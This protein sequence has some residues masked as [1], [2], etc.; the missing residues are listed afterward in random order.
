MGIS[1][2]IGRKNIG[3]YRCKKGGWATCTTSIGKENGRR[4][5]DRR[6]KMVLRKEDCSAGHCQGN[7]TYLG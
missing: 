3:N 4:I 7:L 6:K 2:L 1:S 5:D